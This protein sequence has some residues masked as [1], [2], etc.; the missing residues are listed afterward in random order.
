VRRLTANVAFRAILAALAGL[1]TGLVV[2]AVFAPSSLIVAG[3]IG[4]IATAAAALSSRAVSAPLDRLARAAV[5]SSH[6]SAFHG[7]RR[8]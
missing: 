5:S 3:F 8:S 2:L 6:S 4:A 7:W 1:A